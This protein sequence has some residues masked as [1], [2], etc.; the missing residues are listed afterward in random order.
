[1]VSKHCSNCGQELAT[2]KLAKVAE[3]PAVVF[4]CECG[5]RLKGDLC[6]NQQCKFF[7]EKPDCK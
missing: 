5:R 3:N 6:K 7:D 4:C 2:E 1:M